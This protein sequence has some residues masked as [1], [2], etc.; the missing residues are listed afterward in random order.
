ME[1]EIFTQKYTTSIESRLNNKIRYCF[2][3]SFLVS[4]SSNFLL[5]THKKKT[6][7][8]R[9]SWLQWRVELITYLRCLFKSTRKFLRGCHCYGY[10]AELTPKTEFS[11]RRITIRGNVPQFIEQLLTFIVVCRITTSQETLQQIKMVVPTKWTL[12]L[13]SV[14]FVLTIGISKVVT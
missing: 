3:F 9:T 2:T 12:V 13:S 8:K 11:S 6:L 10:E 4:A 1:T 5:R 7:E 14:H